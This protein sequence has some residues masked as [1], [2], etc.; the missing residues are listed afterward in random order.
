MKSVLVKG[1]CVAGLFASALSI[2]TA[3]A[4]RPSDPRVGLKA[5]SASP[6]A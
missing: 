2:A 4:N 6:P 3:Q 1:L 5:A